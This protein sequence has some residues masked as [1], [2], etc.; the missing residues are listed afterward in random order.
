MQ[1]KK[2]LD[3]FIQMV[4][5][6]KALVHEEIINAL[7]H[8]IRHVPSKRHDKHFPQYRNCFFRKIYTSI[9]KWGLKV[10]K[11]PS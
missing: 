11:Y 1:E 6:R 2:Q 3:V 7:I 8:T 10:W 9:R 4:H 5:F